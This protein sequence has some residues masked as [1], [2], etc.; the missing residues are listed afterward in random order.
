MHGIRHGG[1]APEHGREPDTD[2]RVTRMISS[3]AAWPALPPPEASVPLACLLAGII[4]AQPADFIAL[5]V[6]E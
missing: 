5:S 3:D 2:P 6:L 4:V 1:A